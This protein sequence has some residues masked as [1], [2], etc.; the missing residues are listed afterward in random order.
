MTK[1]RNGFT[2]VELL[3]V[4]TII[5]VLVGLLLP[6]IQ[7]AREAARRMQ[8]TNN[9][10][11]IG[12]ALHNYHDVNQSL[13]PAY[14]FDNFFGWSARILPFVEQSALY[15]S[16]DFDVRL[17]DGANANYIT[18]IIDSYRCPSDP[19]SEVQEISLPYWPSCAP[20]SVARSS[21]GAS[22]GVGRPGVQA[23]RGVFY[24]NSQ[25]RFAD[26]QDGLSNTLAVGERTDY[27]FVNINGG[28]PESLAV[29]AGATHCLDSS[30]QQNTF[31]QT[32]LPINSGGTATFE[33]L[34]P[35]G[36]V[37]LLCDG[38]V[39]FISE[40]IEC[41][42]PVPVD[43]N[44]DLIDSQLGVLQLLSVRDDGQVIGAF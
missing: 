8:C 39:R 6:A 44:N 14:F 41:A 26:I 19:G 22:A 18:T 9:L 31:G 20:L 11:Q 36:A 13:P 43:A 4:I 23:D 24:K 12:V 3:V 37:F 10:K 42:T 32:S 30:I 25:T 1:Q 17:R 7:A 29:W 38:S 35:G 16:L 2:L 40:T 27:V 15:D 28:E 34:H 5:G 21:Y 33:S